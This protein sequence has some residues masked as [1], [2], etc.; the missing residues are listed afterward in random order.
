MKKRNWILGLYDGISQAICFYFVIFF[1]VCFGVDYQ[2]TSS[3]QMIWT[4]PFDG[5]FNK[6]ILNALVKW[7][8]M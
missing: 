8:P 3:Q 6:A 1:F 7:K 2:V 5:E 4:I